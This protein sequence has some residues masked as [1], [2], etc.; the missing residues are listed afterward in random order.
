MIGALIAGI[1]LV[2]MNGAAAGQLFLILAVAGLLAGVVGSQLPSGVARPQDAEV[3]A[4][5]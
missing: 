4:A 5:G 1:A 2:Q 3:S